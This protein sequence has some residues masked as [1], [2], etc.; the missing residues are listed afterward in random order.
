MEPYSAMIGA[1]MNAIGKIASTPPAGPSEAIGRNDSSTQA[2]SGF[3]GQGWTVS[4]GSSKANG[5]S[6]GF[7]VPTLL[8]VGVLAVGAIYLLRKK[9]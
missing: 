7:Q 9:G 2:S 1:G 5:A 3:N 4:T 8:L 6:M